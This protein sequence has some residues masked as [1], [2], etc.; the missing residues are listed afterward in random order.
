MAF[1][2]A[3]KTELD[4]IGA[5]EIIDSS[6]NNTSAY[7]TFENG[8]TGGRFI[9]FDTNSI[10]KLDGSA[11]PKVA[12]VVRRKLTSELNVNIYSSENGDQV[13]EIADFGYVTVEVTDAASPSKR[14]PVYAINVD[15]VESGKATQ[16]S[17]ATGAVLVPDVVFWEEKAAGVWLV[18]INKYL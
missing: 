8:I 2:A 4:N 11:T 18:R 10:D 14:A 6:P 15:S 16:D 13:S 9:K 5:G 7:P 3:V 1:N 17:G 12:G